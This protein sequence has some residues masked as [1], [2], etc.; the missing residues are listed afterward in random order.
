MVL[1]EII[2]L[3]DSRL[4]FCAQRKKILKDAFDEVFSIFKEH[5]V[6][7]A[8]SPYSFEI[9]RVAAL[10]LVLFNVISSI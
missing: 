1:S 8:D 6:I 10:A 2:F 7:T 3:L 9:F 5:L 4:T